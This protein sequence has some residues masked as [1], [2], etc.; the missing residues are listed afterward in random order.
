VTGVADA[1]ID[2]PFIS[3]EVAGERVVEKER[4]ILKDRFLVDKATV[5]DRGGGF[6]GEGLI[7][8]VNL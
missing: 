4:E 8:T 2:V 1:T 6:E 5:V 3:G 7:L